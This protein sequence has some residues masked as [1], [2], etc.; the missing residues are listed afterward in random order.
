M[1]L[2]PSQGDQKERW[3]REL[4][5][6]ASAL[7]GG[8]PA[9]FGPFFNGAVLSSMFSATSESAIRAQP[10]RVATTDVGDTVVAPFDTSALPLGPPV[11]NQTAK[12]ILS[13]SK[14]LWRTN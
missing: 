11:P 12:L 2:Q 5:L 3:W 13:R 6:A 7:A 8:R 1:G 9:N 10:G 14:S 4:Q